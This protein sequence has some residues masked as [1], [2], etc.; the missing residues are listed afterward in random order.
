M[1]RCN[2]QGAD[3]VCPEQTRAV[4]VAIPHAYDV[5]VCS[6]RSQPDASAARHACLGTMLV[7]V[8]PT[9]G[10]AIAP[11]ASRESG[12]FWVCFANK[13]KTV[14]YLVCF[15]G[16][17]LDLLGNILSSL[18]S[19]TYEK[20]NGFARSFGRLWPFTNSA[21]LVVKRTAEFEARELFATG[22]NP[23]PPPARARRTPFSGG[24]GP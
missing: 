6:Q 18:E 14:E 13:A 17:R 1:D 20:L 16:V 19:K 10:R 3:C 4:G 5:A 24:L 9:A 2:R 12:E 15:L 11:Q 23:C 8:Q 21:A 7:S 22:L